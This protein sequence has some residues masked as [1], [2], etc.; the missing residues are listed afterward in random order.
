MKLYVITI[1]DV[2]DYEG[3]PVKPIIE[4]SRREA[5]K[6]LAELKRSA[7]ETYKNQYNKEDPANPDK[8][9]LYPDG[10]WGTSHYDARI[11]EV[12]IPIPITSVA[13]VSVNS[14]EILSLDVKLFTDSKDASKHMKGQMRAEYRDAETSGY[15]DITAESSEKKASVVYPSGDDLQQYKWNMQET[16]L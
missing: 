14:N 8:F 12:D 10:F 2:Y 11:D 7:K 15:E 4:L 9:S 13:S 6:R 1:D 3:F 16:T 5:R